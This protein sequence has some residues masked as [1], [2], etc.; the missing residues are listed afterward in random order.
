MAQDD[1]SKFVPLSGKAEF[2]LFK[3]AV[4]NGRFYRA[5]PDAPVRVQLPYPLREGQG[6][7]HLRLVKVLVEPKLKNGKSKAKEV[8]P[9]DDND[10]LPGD[11]VQLKPVDANAVLLP[12][13]WKRAGKAFLE[14]WADAIGADKDQSNPKLVAALEAALKSGKAE[15]FDGTLEELQASAG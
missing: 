10:E 13:G 12:R 8:A 14:A 7:R 5:S 2:D 6:R 15:I 4:V 9:A 1:T 11:P 3:K